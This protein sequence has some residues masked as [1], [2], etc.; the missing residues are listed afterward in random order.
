VKKVFVL[1]H[2]EARS[3]AAQ[4]LKEAPDGYAVTISEPTRNLD[5]AC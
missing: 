4:A 2:Q 1:V 5:I 3:R